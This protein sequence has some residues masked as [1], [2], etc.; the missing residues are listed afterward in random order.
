MSTPFKW[1]EL[2]EIRPDQFDLMSFKDRWAD[3]G[4]LASDI[5]DNPG[6]LDKAILWVMADEQNGIGDA[7]W[8]PHYPKMPGEPPRVQPSKRRMTEN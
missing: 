4:D 5:G 7:P 1:S 3:V 2:D 8:P 6:R